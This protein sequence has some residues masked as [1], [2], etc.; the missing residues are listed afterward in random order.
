VELSVEFEAALAGVQYIS[1][2]TVLIDLV[3]KELEDGW[4]YVWRHLRVCHRTFREG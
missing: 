3:L 4:V 1:D 2:F